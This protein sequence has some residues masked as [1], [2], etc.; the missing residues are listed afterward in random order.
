MWGVKRKVHLL[1][2]DRINEFIKPLKIYRAKSLQVAFPNPHISNTGVLANDPRFVS[3]A[4]AYKKC[5]KKHSGSIHAE[6]S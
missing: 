5:F 4:A 2:R 6:I 3:P 1:H